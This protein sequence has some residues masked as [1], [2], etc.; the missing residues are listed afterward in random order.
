MMLLPLSRTVGLQDTC[1]EATLA[2]SG[3]QARLKAALSVQEWI[4]GYLGRP[5]MHPTEK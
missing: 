4:L 3:V 5:Q 2:K 1:I